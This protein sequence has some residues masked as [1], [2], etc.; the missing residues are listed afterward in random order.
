MR[1]KYIGEDWE[2][3]NLVPPMKINLK[4]NEIYNVN[5]QDDS[6]VIAV[7]GQQMATEPST[8]NV[9]FPQGA[10]IPYMPHRFVKCWKQV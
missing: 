5:I 1:L 8:I 2:Y 7:N 9:I 6:Q 10:W 4:R 3:E